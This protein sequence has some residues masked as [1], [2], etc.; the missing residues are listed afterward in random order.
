MPGCGWSP[1]WFL[2]LITELLTTEA[3]AQGETACSGKHAG[4]RIFKMILLGG[5]KRA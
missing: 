4:G 1:H 3:G 2:H 5:Q